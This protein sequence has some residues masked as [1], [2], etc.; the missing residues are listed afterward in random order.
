MTA[1]CGVPCVH[2]LIGHLSLPEPVLIDYTIG[3]ASGPK[4]V[5]LRVEARTDLQMRCSE[6]VGGK[7]ADK[8]RADRHEKALAL[9]RQVR[10]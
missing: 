1:L 9:D 10:Q 4:V 2:V 7:K 3:E 5:D 6:A 8:E